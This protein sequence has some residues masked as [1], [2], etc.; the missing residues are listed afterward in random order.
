MIVAIGA[1]SP[2]GVEG[3]VDDVATITEQMTRDAF[4]ALPPGAAPTR[5]QIEAVTAA[6]RRAVERIAALRVPSEMA[7][8]HTVL[9]GALD[10][11]VSAAEEFLDS[12]ADLDPE[13]F[14]EAVREATDIDALAD[15]VGAACSA[16][17]RRAEELVRPVE[18][19]C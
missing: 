5:P 15:R 19:G 16:W 7:A 18:L 1:C 9:V 6:R 11:F 3:Y 17:E 13:A 10:Q 14:L 4:A 8:E 12:T 2:P